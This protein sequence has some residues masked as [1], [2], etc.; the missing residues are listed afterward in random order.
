MHLAPKRNPQD[1]LG[2]GRFQLFRLNFQ[3]E[4]IS[5]GRDDAKRKAVGIRSGLEGDVVAPR[6]EFG[7]VAE[8]R[9]V[10]RFVFAVAKRRRKISGTG[11][12]NRTCGR[13]WDLQKKK[14]HGKNRA[15]RQC[16]T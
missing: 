1:F 7:H 12:K 6:A 15:L 16:G 3:N 10:I 8:V 11:N 14:T 4:V 2:V 9:G 13:V 5:I